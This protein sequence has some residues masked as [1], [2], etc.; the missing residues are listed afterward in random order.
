MLSEGLYEKLLDQELEELLS[1]QP[2]LLATFDKLDDE[3]EPHAF[4]EGLT[5]FFVECV[6]DLELAL[7]LQ[8]Y[9][10]EHM[11]S[12]VCLFHLVD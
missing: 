5:S 8:V 6:V 2:E 9:I 10:P 3:A 4:P 1:Q 12:V 11:T 7:S